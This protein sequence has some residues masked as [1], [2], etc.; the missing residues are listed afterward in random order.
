MLPRCGE[1]LRIAVTDDRRPFCR[2]AAD[3]GRFI[4]STAKSG[5]A[6]NLFSVR[7]AARMLGHRRRKAR[8]LQGDS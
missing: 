2:R 4:V 3:A 6:K 5:E 8:H 1:L 7:Q